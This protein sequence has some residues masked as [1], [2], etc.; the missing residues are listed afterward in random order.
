M[1]SPFPSPTKVTFFGVNDHNL[2]QVIL[3]CPVRDITKD[4]LSFKEVLGIHDVICHS[5]GPNKIF[6]TLHVEVDGYSNIMEIHD[7]IDNIEME[8]GKK[9]GAE[10]TIHMDPI[11]TKNPEIPLIKD[12]INET[13]KSLNNRITFHDLRLV[14]GPTHTN[15]LF[16]IVI[17]SGIKIEKSTIISALQISINSIDKKYILVIKIDSSYTNY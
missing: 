6:I 17:P 11:D 14:A 5:Y 12:K 1:I 4:I 16:D 9:Y 7:V 3:A 10:I 8:I 13:L 15:I 2:S